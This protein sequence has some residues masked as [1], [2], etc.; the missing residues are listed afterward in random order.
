MVT[1]EWCIFAPQYDICDAYNGCCEY[2]RLSSAVGVTKAPFVNLSV[3]K[4]F[5]LAK[6]HVKFLESHLYLTCV[7]AAELRQ[8]QSDINAIFNS[9][10]VFDNDE[11]LGK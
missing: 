1:T 6:V 11:N 5:D 3:S 4:I 8:H 9:L 7:P 2:M 10:S